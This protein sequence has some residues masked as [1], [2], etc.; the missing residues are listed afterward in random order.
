MWRNAAVTLLGLYF[1]VAPWWTG[2]ADQTLPT[3]V[4]VLG[5]AVLAGLFGWMTVQRQRPWLPALNWVGVVIGFWFVLH[6]FLGHFEIGSFWGYVG[7]AIAVMF[8][9]IWTLMKGTRIGGV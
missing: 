8:L 3:V 5:G 1:L 7:P 6:P 4:S 2:T 9:N